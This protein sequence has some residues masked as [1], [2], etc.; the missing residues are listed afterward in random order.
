MIFR[1]LR[2]IKFLFMG[3]VILGILVLINWVTSPGH[4]WLQWAALGIGIAWI[5]SLFRVI[6]AV[7][8]AGGIAA[9][10]TTLRK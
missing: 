4:W 8:V 10:I 1:T 7:L 9:L 2:A 5:I 3:P 6:F